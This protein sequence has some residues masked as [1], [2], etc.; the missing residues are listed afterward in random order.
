MN[1]AASA[2]TGVSAHEVVYGVD[3]LFHSD[4]NLSVK[5]ADLFKT[6]SAG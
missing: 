1:A 3:C 5:T 4:F 2:T 6:E